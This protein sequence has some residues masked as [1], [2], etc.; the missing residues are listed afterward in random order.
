MAQLTPQVPV[1]ALTFVLTL[2]LTVYG[3]VQYHRRG[4]TSELLSFVS[5]MSAIS[6]WELAGI[7]IVTTQSVELKHSLYN[8]TNAIPGLLIP[9]TFVWFALAYSERDRWVNR[10]TVGVVG[11]HIVAFSTALV[12]EPEFLYEVDGLVTQGP[13]TAP[14]VTFE[15]W[16]VLDR[17]LKRPFLVH[18]L[19]VYSAFLLGGG[20]L[21]HHMLRNQSSLYSGQAVALAVGFGTPLLAN[22]LLFVGLLPPE[23]NTTSIAL[24]VTAVAFAIAIFRYRLL[25]IAPVGRQQLFEELDM[26]VFML[27]EEDRVVDSNTAARELA[28]A[29]DT[30]RGV[31]AQQ[32]FASVPEQAEY[33]NDVNEARSETSLTKAGRL[34][35]FDLNVSPIQTDETDRE[36][37]LVILQEIT[38]RKERERQL[39]LMRQ[40]L[41]RVLRH[42][43]RNDLQVVKGNVELLVDNLDGPHEEMAATAV[44][45]SEELLSVSRKARE[46]EEVID[47]DQHPTEIDLKTTLEETLGRYQATYPDV[48]FTLDCPDD[49]HVL[50]SPSIENILRNLVENGAEHNDGSHQTVDVTVSERSDVTIVSVRDNGPGIPNSELDIL[51]QNEET[52]LEHGSGIGLW[53]VQ[54]AVEN[55]DIS[56]QYDTS[57]SGTEITLRI[58]HER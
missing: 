21:G 51:E 2:S 45:S 52:S 34:R 16:V 58:P 10:W 53:I 7:L 44:D 6:L 50:V 46:I 55:T 1:Y 22:G 4:H 35:H 30:W 26:P 38:E 3:A 47:P 5:M 12:V 56:I 49:C 25:R 15:G 40:V 32:F 11:V 48:E 29:P 23:L 13:A 9:Y 39:N 37:K 33:L 24:S 42:N 18:Q 43:V 27:D 8:F 14:G 36:G 31:P 17:T 57:S 28:D 19:F 54:W 20:I 41:S